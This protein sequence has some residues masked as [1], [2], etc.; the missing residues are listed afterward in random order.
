MRELQRRRRQERSNVSALRQRAVETQISQVP[1]RIFV[2]EHIFND[3]DD[4]NDVDADLDI[5]Q[6]LR[7]WREN[8]QT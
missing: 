3:D 4:E 5:L 7:E 1:E 6:E 2:P 8:N